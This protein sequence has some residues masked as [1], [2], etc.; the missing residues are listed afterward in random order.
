MDV[1][2]APTVG[3]LEQYASSAMAAVDNSRYAGCLTESWLAERL[4]VDVAHLDVRRRG[5]ELLAVRPEGADEWFYPAWQFDGGRVRPVVPG[6]VA[7]AQANGIDERR[8]YDLMTVR[9]GL[10]RSETLV[11]LL[12]RGEDDR[13]VAAI[14]R[15]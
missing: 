12:L 7:A 2:S 5:G 10:G 3:S 1:V 9:R 8:L 13:V 11:D 15:G 6:I 4:G 14:R